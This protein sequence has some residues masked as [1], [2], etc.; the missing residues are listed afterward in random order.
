MWNLVYHIKE[1]L[2]AGGWCAVTMKTTDF[3]AV[4]PCSLEGGILCPSSGWKSKPSPSQRKLRTPRDYIQ[5]DR[6][7]HMLRVF[8]N[9]VLRW[10]LGRKRDEMGRTCRTHGT[11]V[12]VRYYEQ[13][14]LL[15]RLR[16]TWEDNI[17]MHLQEIGW[18]SVDW[19]NLAQDRKQRRIL[20][21]TVMNL[22]VLK[23]SGNFLQ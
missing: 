8:E 5:E 3:W 16:F 15:G 14:I 19:I 21:I 4:T 17:K 12:M 6:T 13:K 20:V 11:Q 9:R 1:S 22:R 2:Y 7:S 18:E 10:I 23:N